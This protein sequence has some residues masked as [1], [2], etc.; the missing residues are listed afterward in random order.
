ME[1]LANPRADGHFL[2]IKARTTRT[3]LIRT[4]RVQKLNS[5]RGGEEGK[6]NPPEGW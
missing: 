5:R 1:T 6:W 3:S 2:S 4:Y